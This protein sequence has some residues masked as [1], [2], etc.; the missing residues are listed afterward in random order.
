M[1]AMRI[2]GKRLWVIIRTENFSF[3]S[4][5][6]IHELFIQSIMTLVSYFTSSGTAKIFL[7]GGQGMVD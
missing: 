6:R 1:D 7:K 5:V 3:H 2:K 4:V